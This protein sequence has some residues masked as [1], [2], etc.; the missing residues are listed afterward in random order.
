MPSLILELES[1][2][3]NPA[4]RISDLL[5]KAK[6]VSKKLHALEIQKWIDCELRLSEGK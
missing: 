4:T 5:R 3:M 1:D 6:A 2:A